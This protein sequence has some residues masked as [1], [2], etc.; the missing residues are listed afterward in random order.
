MHIPP[1]QF[2]RR[3]NLFTQAVRFFFPNLICIRDI[4][5]NKKGVP[6]TW[7][8]WFVSM[9]CV[10]IDWHLVFIGNYMN[11]I[12]IAMSNLSWMTRLEVKPRNLALQLRKQKGKQKVPSHWTFRPSQCWEHGPPPLFLLHVASQDSEI[13]ETS[14]SS[15][16]SNCRWQWKEHLCKK[17]PKPPVHVVLIWN[18]IDI[19][20]Q[21]LGSFYRCSFPYNIPKKFKGWNT[22]DLYIN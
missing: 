15:V 7:N 13:Q 2:V 18:E 11:S 19:S 10:A 9:P 21:L 14:A 6:I 22:S 5:F 8:I 20:T 16:S 4:L 3:K 17:E 1:L 12:V